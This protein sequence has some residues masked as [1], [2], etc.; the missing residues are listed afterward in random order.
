MAGNELGIRIPGARWMTGRTATERSAT[1]AK[2]ATVIGRTEGAG[3]VRSAT[4]LP[5]IE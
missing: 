1:I 3:V 4:A 5:F 2:R